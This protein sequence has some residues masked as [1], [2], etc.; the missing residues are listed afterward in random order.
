MLNVVSFGEVLFDVFPTHLKI[1][2]APLN[3]ALRLQSLGA[4]ISMVSSIGT[5]NKG[6]RIKDYLNHVGL[7]TSTIQTHPTLPTSE[8]L[9]KLD[10][11]GAATYTIVAPVAWDEIE[12][13]DLNIQKVSESDLFLFGSLAC[14]NN[15]S[16]KTL[17]SLIKHAKYNVFD[18]NLRAPHYTKSLLLELIDKAN[19]VKFND[20]ELFEIA[21]F[22][23]C[24]FNGMEQTI[25]FIANKANLDTI[26]VTKGAF[27]AV[28]YHQGLFYYNSGY[29]VKVSDTVGSGDSFLASL[30]YKL[31]TGSNSQE[32]VDYACAVGA[33]VAGC[34]GANPNIS[35]E[36]INHFMNPI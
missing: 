21:T 30:L 36:A 25:K 23:D 1:G 24:K 18:V 15:A 34:E 16:E 19:F 26:C 4:Q 3:V 28:L 31:F 35:I 22:M 8:V 13:T 11:K 9:V 5:D 12:L 6:I 33:L 2:G 10:D 14:R 29:R 32:A 7:D 20:D 17:K 27:G